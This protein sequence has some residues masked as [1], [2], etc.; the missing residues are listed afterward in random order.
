MPYD[1]KQSH[2]SRT[3]YSPIGGHV[4]TGVQNS[5]PSPLSHR[6][7][8]LTPPNWNMKHWKSVKSGNPL[9]EK[10]LYITVNLAPFESKVFTHCSCY[11]GP[12]RKQSSLLYVTVA[13]VPH[14]R[15]GTLHI[16]VAIG[17]PF[18]GRVL[19]YDVVRNTLRGLKKGGPR[20]V[21]RL[22][23]LKHTPVYN[24][25]NDRIWEYETDW[26]HS[27]SSDMCTVSPDV[28]M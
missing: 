11:W 6:K 24:P 14:W 26:T 13:V 22:P 8:A 17:G 18:E 7:R 25:D 12:L 5:D 1:Y 20:Q 28:R 23:S 27:A 19:N 4:A 15:Q 2:I 21:P 3:P 16:T 9:K 10:C